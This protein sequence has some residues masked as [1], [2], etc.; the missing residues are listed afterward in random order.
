MHI[1][2]YFF[3][4]CDNLAKF[5]NPFGRSIATSANASKNNSSRVD[6]IRLHDN[7]SMP[8]LKQERKLEIFENAAEES[9]ESIGG[10]NTER[11]ERLTSTACNYCC[12]GDLCNRATC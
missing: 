8:D 3:Q 6:L 4:V 9:H 11:G 1:V 5:T 2:L 10:R 7:I 12:H